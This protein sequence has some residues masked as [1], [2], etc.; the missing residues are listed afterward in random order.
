MRLSFLNLSTNIAGKCL[1]TNEL[2]SDGHCPQRDAE[3]SSSEDAVCFDDYFTSVVM[4]YA[5]KILLTESDTKPRSSRRK[6]K[7]KLATNAKCEEKFEGSTEWQGL[8]PWD[9]SAGG[10][11]CP[12]FLCDVMVIAS[13]VPLHSTVLFIFLFKY[14]FMRWTWKRIWFTL[15]KI[16]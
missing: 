4:K 10:D 15:Y 14:C 9:P 8:P 5:E 16:A 7:Q 12:K 11:G 6:E 3:C 1:P 13:L 2:T